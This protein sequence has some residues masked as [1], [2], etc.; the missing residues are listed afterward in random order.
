MSENI[1]DTISIEFVPKRM[2]TTE[3]EHSQYARL[4]DEFQ[5]GVEQ[6][7]QTGRTV[8]LERAKKRAEKRFHLIS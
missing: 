7:I 8:L 3:L 4:V 5:E 1:Y 2:P 6:F